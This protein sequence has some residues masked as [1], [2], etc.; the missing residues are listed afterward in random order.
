MGI[1]ELKF[2]IILLDAS[3]FKRFS[4]SFIVFMFGRLDLYLLSLYFHLYSILRRNNIF[5]YINFLYLFDFFLLSYFLKTYNFF[6][7]P[8]VIYFKWIPLLNFILFIMSYVTDK[9]FAPVC[10]T[11]KVY[12]EGAKDVALSALSGINGNLF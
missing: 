10:S 3:K 8:L 11:Q 5:T 9:V 7:W 6:L 4:C 12:E 1:N 2:Y